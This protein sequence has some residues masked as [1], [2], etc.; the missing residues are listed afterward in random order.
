MSL[1][2]CTTFISEYTEILAMQFHINTN[3][4][5]NKRRKLGLPLQTCLPVV[6]QISKRDLFSVR[7]AKCGI[8]TCTGCI[9]KIVE[10]LQY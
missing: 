8:A 2:Y 7:A 10:E 3:Y 1:V 4:F 5:F 9:Y 6:R